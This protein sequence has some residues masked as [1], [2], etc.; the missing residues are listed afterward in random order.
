MPSAQVRKLLHFSWCVPPVIILSSRYN[1]LISY[2]IGDAQASKIM[3]NRGR[4]CPFRA[5]LKNFRIYYNNGASWHSIERELWH[6]LVHKG[7][8]RN[9]AVAVKKILIKTSPLCSFHYG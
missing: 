1:T 3:S 7:Q 8:G 4:C 2:H 5:F 6:L 9:I